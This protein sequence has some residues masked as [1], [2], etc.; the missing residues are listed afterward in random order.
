MPTFR[1]NLH[2]GDKDPVIDSDS[3]AD[4]SITTDKIADD[5]V[6]NAKLACDSVGSCQIQDGAVS[7]E[8][9]TEGVRDAIN[10][11]GGNSGLDDKIDKLDKAA[12][13][14]ITLNS[15]TA[16]NLPDNNGNVRLA[17][18]TGISVNGANTVSPDPSGV[19]HIATGGGGGGADPG[20][21]DTLNSSVQ[22]LLRQFSNDWEKS[23]QVVLLQSDMSTAQNDIKPLQKLAYDLKQVIFLDFLTGLNDNDEDPYP[24]ASAYWL[25]AGGP[26]LYK[27][28]AEDGTLKWKG[29]GD[30]NGYLYVNRNNGNLYRIED[31]ELESLDLSVDTSYKDKLYLHRDTGKLYRLNGNT[32]E[33]V[34]PWVSDLSNSSGGVKFAYVQS[35]DPTSDEEIEVSEGDL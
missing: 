26:S 22:W 18:V 2:L 16:K 15:G 27:G 23:Q 14:S 29:Q 32:L 12:V 3:I 30:S 10:S 1:D 11:G 28:V 31:D 5:A 20:A 35:I 7:L 34:K 6:T 17:V 25:D 9:L 13:K 33:E 8:K 19:L 24:V 21:L 4:G